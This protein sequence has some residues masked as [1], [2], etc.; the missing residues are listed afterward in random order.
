M[1]L[2]YAYGAGLGHLKRVSDFIISEK[3]FPEDCLILTNSKYSDFWQNKWKIISIE[4]FI[5]KNP[6]LFFTFFQEIESRYTIEKFIVDTFPLGFHGELK[7]CIKQFKNEKILLA[8]IL[9]KHYFEKY[10]E[11]FYYSTIYIIEKGIY[12]PAKFAEK[13]K[14]YQLK[15]YVKEKEIPKNLNF[16]FFLII[17]SQPLSEVIYLYKLADMYRTN[18]KIVILTMEKA[19]TPFWDCTNTYIFYTTQTALNFIKRAEKIFS[20]CGFNTMRLL[21]EWENKCLFIPFPRTYDDQFLRKDNYLHMNSN[22]IID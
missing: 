17:H 12:Y 7:E 1:I 9:S 21:S 11:S 8:R 3:I 20:G 22:F 16:P 18:Q 15:Y 14:P 13:I 5:F 6:Q 4:P 2:I 19:T 10:S